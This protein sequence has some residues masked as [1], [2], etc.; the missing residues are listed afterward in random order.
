[1]RPLRSIR[2]IFSKNS[3]RSVDA[4]RPVSPV[5]KRQR[6]KGFTKEIKREMKMEKEMRQDTKMEVKTDPK[7]DAK[8]GAQKETIKAKKVEER[9]MLASYSTIGMMFPASIGVGL[10]MG[11]FLDKWLNTSPYLLISFTLYGI[12]AGFYNL[13]K[14]T[15]KKEKKEKK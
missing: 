4:I 2:S 7:N 9:K 10:A 13:F 8:T 11:Y 1:M 15:R 6:R 14:I 12:A 5:Q 3:L